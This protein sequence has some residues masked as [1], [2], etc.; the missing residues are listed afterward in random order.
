MNN[1][2][3]TAAPPL[4]RLHDGALPAELNWIEDFSQIAPSHTDI[5]AK[6]HVEENEHGAVAV[7]AVVLAGQFRDRAAATGWLRSKGFRS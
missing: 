5:Q 6:A 1:A 7:I 4:S 3:A 2:P